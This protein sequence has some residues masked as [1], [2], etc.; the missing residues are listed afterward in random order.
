MDFETKCFKLYL[1]KYPKQAA[2]LV[3]VNAAVKLPK[4]IGY[5]L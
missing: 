2:M 1:V 4:P 5:K 3:E